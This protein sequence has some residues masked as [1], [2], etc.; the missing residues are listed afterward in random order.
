VV[1]LKKAGL[2]DTDIQKLKNNE[3]VT[4]YEVHHKIPLDDGGTNDMSNFVL[5]KKTPYHHAL[6]TEQNSFSRAMTIGQTKTV[7]FPIPK[8]IVYSPK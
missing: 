6:T 4:G 8:G 2:S 3:N 7:N 1:K 5:I